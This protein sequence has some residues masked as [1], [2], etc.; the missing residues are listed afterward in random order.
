MIWHD[1]WENSYAGLID[2]ICERFSPSSVTYMS[3]GALRFQPEQKSIMRERF[4]LDSL[5]TRAEMF[6]SRDGKLRYDANLRQKMFQFIM[7]R[8]KLRSSDWR[9][10]LCMETPETWVKATGASPF[11]SGELSDL[12]APHVVHK[13]RIAR[14]AAADR[15]EAAA[16]P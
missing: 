7:D 14:T 4:G 6:P 10:F 16:H 13:A 5:I 1:E 3:V 2:A 9:I 15:S 8:F 11:K 12:F